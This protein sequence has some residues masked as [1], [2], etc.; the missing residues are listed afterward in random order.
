MYWIWFF[1]G[2]IL[3]VVCVIDFNVLI[4]EQVE[5]LFVVYLFVWEV[6]NFV[7]FVEWVGFFDF[8]FNC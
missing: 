4:V 5:Y 7:L 6:E 8:F 2:L 1:F 3:C